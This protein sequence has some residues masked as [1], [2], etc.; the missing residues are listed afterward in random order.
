MCVYNVSDSI[1][2]L[3]KHEN[4]DQALQLSKYPQSAIEKKSVIKRT[5]FETSQ[6]N[7]NVPE[8]QLCLS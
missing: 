1:I 4:R 8:E 7:I 2:L 6:S 5:V 3:L